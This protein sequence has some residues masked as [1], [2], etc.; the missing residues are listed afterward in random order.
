MEIQRR[1]Q[2]NAITWSGG[3]EGVVCEVVLS[4]QSI[5]WSGKN[6]L[7]GSRRASRELFRGMA[8]LWRR[9]F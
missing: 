5:D 8:S 4:G 1:D 3:W 2:A 6:E 7:V 9:F